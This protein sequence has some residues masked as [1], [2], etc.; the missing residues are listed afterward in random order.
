MTI[1]ANNNKVKKAEDSKTK[2]RMLEA[3]AILFKTSIAYKYLTKWLSSESQDECG[4]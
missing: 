3:N 4:I 1:I 2:I